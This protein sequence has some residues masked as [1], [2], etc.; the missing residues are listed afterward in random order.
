M[1]RFAAFGCLWTVLASLAG[2][3]GTRAIVTSPPSASASYRLVPEAGIARYT[4][5]QGQV[6]SGAGLLERIVPDYPPELL[7]A[8]PPLV[9]VHAQLIVDGSGKVREVRVTDKAQAGT[10]RRTHI[11]ATRKAALQWSF[12]PLHIG[13]RSADADGTIM[14]WTTKSGRSVWSMLS[15]SAACVVAAAYSCERDRLVD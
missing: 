15:T 11:A 8:C 4:L 5:T 12:E 6:A 1:R 2:C 7:A 13:H 9:E 3:A 14:G 10:A